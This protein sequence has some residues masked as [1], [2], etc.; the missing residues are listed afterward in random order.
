[1]DDAKPKV[2][3]VSPSQGKMVKCADAAS[4]NPTDGL[5]KCRRSLKVY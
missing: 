3:G 4:S 5:F 2:P 1:M